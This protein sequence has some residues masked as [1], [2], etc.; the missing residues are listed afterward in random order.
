MGKR[1]A[2]QSEFLRGFGG[3]K[4]A[5]F[6]SWEMFGKKVKFGEIEGRNETFE[7]AK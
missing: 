4:S 7:R 2:M 6:W 5:L 1:S 3:N